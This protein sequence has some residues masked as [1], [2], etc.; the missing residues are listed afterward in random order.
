MKINPTEI[1][2]WLAY[3]V[4]ASYRLVKLKECTFTPATNT[5][6]SVFL[7]DQG[8]ADK[9]DAL[10]TRL[11]REYIASVAKDGEPS[12]LKHTFTYEKSYID[13]E[14]LRLKVENFL[15]KQFSVLT[16]DLDD[17]DIKVGEGRGSFTVNI[18]IPQQNITYIEKSRA[19]AEFLKTLHDEYFSTFQIMLNPKKQD[20]DDGEVLDKLE[21]YMKSALPPDASREPGVKV[22][23]ALKIRAAEYLLGKPIKERPVK[24]EFLRITAEEQV[25]AGTIANLTHR[26][27]TKKDTNEKKPYFTFLL[28]DGRNRASCIYF[29]NQKTLAKFET[30][31]NGNT[32]LVIGENS[33]RNGRTGFRVAGI[34]TCELV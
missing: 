14:I 29:P 28:D 15:K 24:I 16:L 26:E 12:D 20:D 7:F 30:L 33:E 1:T 9:I 6:S 18:Y 3:N 22:D 31:Q 11:E 27:Y 34:S 25:I 8:I 2:D 23:K 17:G 21:Q 5:L 19:F 13:A 4:D 10:K 32:V